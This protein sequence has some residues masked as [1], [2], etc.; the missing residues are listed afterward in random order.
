[1]VIIF[2][3]GNND[4]Q[5]LQTK[6]NA[7]RV[8]LENIM[9]NINLSFNEKPSYFYARI[10]LGSEDV[11][12][13]YSGGFMNDS[14][15]VLEA[16]CK[17]FKLNFTDEKSKLFILHDDSDQLEGNQK[18]VVG[19]GSAGHNGIKSIYKHIFNLDLSTEKIWRLKI[20]IRPSDNKMKSETFVLSRFGEN[21]FVG[22]KKL[23]NKLT[24]LLPLLVSE[25]LSRLQTIFNSSLT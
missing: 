17:Y 19:G 18:L 8:V 13:L 16:F 23:A 24:D 25:D 3:L 11:Y 15:Q 14:G 10:K 9:K 5:Y 7:G 20:G 4:K 12:F 1:M 2:G 21:E 6:H 22:Y